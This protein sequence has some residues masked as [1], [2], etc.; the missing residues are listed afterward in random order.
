[1]HCMNELR[2]R[3]LSKY[4]SFLFMIVL[5]MIPIIGM[6]C[7]TCVIL[8]FMLDFDMAM[9]L[10]LTIFLIPLTYSTTLYATPSIKIMKE[11]KYIDLDHLRKFVNT[12]AF[13]SLYENL[14]IKILVREGFRGGFSM[15]V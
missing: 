8:Y 4:L 6:I 9:I 13:K 11:V 3:M 10:T 2:L 1:M 12:E 5:F 7:M 15:A 14:F